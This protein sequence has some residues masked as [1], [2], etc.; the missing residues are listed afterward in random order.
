MNCANVFFAR[1]E[2]TILQP[3]NREA[4]SFSSVRFAPA[5]E[6]RPTRWEPAKEVHIREHDAATVACV[7]RRARVSYT[8][9]KGTKLE[10]GRC[11]S[12]ARH[13]V[14]ARAHTHPLTNAHPRSSLTYTHARTH[15][16]AYTHKPRTYRMR[17]YEYCIVHV[18]TL[19]TQIQAG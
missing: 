10:T 2:S 8:I 18:H 12:T 14:A 17:T 5:A 16:H 9:C 19:N 13:I 7:T 15:T 1:L 6:R 11:L 3:F 4:G